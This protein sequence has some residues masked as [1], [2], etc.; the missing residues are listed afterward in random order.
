M[1]RASSHPGGRIWVPPSR[2][3]RD[4][5]LQLGRLPLP[6]TEN[7]EHMKSNADVDFEIAAEDMETL[8]S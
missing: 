4:Y 1:M 3:R 6:K 5:T 2:R 8:K 7:P